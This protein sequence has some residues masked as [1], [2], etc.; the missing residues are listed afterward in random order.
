LDRLIYSS[1]A[2]GRADCL[3][4]VATI[5][6]VSHRNNERDGLTGALAAHNGRYLQ[7]V[8]GTP[9]ALDAL[10]RRLEADDRHRD[11]ILIDREPVSTRLFDGWTMAHARVTPALAAVLE[12][13]VHNPAAD[14][15]GAV[16]IL[17]QASRPAPGDDREE[18]QPE[19]AHASRPLSP[20][21]SGPSADA[22]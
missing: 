17:H 19:P 20:S 3:T 12:S 11:L 18:T 16:E 5:L 10:L 7:V 9:D 14:P 22:A 2:T 8:E 6:G 4:T 21:S 1:V 13:L 15:G